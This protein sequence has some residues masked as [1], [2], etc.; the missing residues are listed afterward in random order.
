[1][2]FSGVVGYSLSTTHSSK[3]LFRR[4]LSSH[5]RVNPS[6][7]NVLN[8]CSGSGPV[9]FPDDSLKKSDSEIKNEIVGSGGGNGISFSAASQVEDGSFG[10]PMFARLQRFVPFDLREKMSL[11][12]LLSLWYASN[13]Y[14]NVFNKEVLQQFFFP[15]TCTLVQFA[16]GCAISIIFWVFKWH[17]LPHL[18]NDTPSRI[19]FLACL[20]VLGFTLTNVSLGLVSVS[21]THTVKATEPFFSVALSQ[22]ILGEIPTV[23]VCLSLIPIVFG[24]AIASATEA[25]FNW[26]GFL[27]AMGSNL[28]FQSRNSFSK[29]FM[30]EVSDIDNINLYFLM[31]IASFF[32]LIPFSLCIE[33]FPLRMEAL[34]ASGISQSWIFT[35]L[36]LAGLFRCA[37]V[38]ISYMILQRVSPVTHSVSNSVKRAIVICASV[39][40]F[41]TPTSPLNILGT[42]IA[43][44]GVYCYSAILS[45]LKKID[46]ND[47]GL[48]YRPINKLFK[49]EQYF[50]GGSGI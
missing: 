39:I 20:H 21:F 6:P 24:V 36:L 13:T 5:R 17:T 41:G 11:V 42:S 40:I 32:L 28:A 27:A 46:V 38:L 37:D 14:F 18:Q 48:L 50:T 3:N 47:E 44:F 2:I 8:Y 43:L 35:R 15:I 45:K 33:G 30:N 49:G 31:T 23:G 19:I 29:K 7:K 25:S 26:T 4:S 22:R 34:D 9:D 10:M 1:M 16:V 12:L